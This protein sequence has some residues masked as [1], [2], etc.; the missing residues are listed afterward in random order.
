M[1]LSLS[2]Q[3]T[4]TSGTTIISAQANTNFD[5]IYNAFTGL[6]GMTKS[7]TSLLV[8]TTLR[9]GGTIQSADG[10][11]GAP[12]LT[13]ASD[14]DTGAYRI[15][16]DNFAFATAG[17][18]CLEFSTTAITAALPIAMGGNKLTGLGAGTVSGEAL[19]YE[20]LVGAY[21][22]LAGGTLTAVGNTVPLTLDRA[23]S[24]SDIAKFASGAT[25][26]GEIDN[27]GR[28]RAANGTVGSPGLSFHNETDC[29]FM[30]G[31]TNQI[32]I[33]TNGALRW[34][35]IASG[36]LNPNGAG[37]ISIGD[38]GNYVNDISYKTLT[39]RGCLGW[40][41]EGVELQDGTVVTDTA[42]IA[43]IRKHPTKKT[44]YGVDMLDYAT[45]PK[46]AYKKA[47]VRGELLPRDENNEPYWTDKDGARCTAAD[48]I[49]MTS[50]F[51]IMLG[52]IKE[53]TARVAVLENAV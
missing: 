3:Y 4:F 13:W 14:L 42:A 33:V 20:Q 26:Y 11:V 41:D 35:F 37:L 49:E 1:S 52:A 29:G 39:D 30:V 50:M 27:I 7:L 21:L 44:I 2:K 19:R 6:E 48:G 8:D 12:G 18:K 46:V 47:E 17:V 31:G 25:I 38:A 45:F 16:A 15:G 23:S 51:S 40:F 28:I 5:D 22:P 32:D 53:L 36:F 24:N 10:A 43:A 34:S 9:S